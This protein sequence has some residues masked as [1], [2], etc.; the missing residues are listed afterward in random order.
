MKKNINIIL[1]DDHHLFRDGIKF[2]LSRISDNIIIGEASNGVEFL[3]MLQLNVPDLVLMDIAMPE[4]DGIE[5]TSK[6]HE[7]YPELKIIA[8]SSY[9]D[10]V[11][12]RKMIEVGAQG[13]LTKNSNV[14]EFE[15]AIN[16]VING[17]NYFSQDLLKKVVLNISNKNQKT[18]KC[19][20][21]RLTNREK[22]VLSY[23]CQG[24][25]NKEIAEKLFI[26]PKTVDNH[27]TNLLNKT[28]SK[29]TAS[30]VMCAIKNNLIAI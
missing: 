19:D 17:N 14:E 30:L 22:D 20:F 24:L 23:I 28:S 6:A 13:F 29:N 4:M 27:R 12:Y 10:E 1:V 11:Y 3:E 26:S 18:E 7:L 8:L 5:A 21:T 2:I 16:T 15:Y 9:G 25:S